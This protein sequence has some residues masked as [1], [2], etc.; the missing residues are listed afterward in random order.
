M[1]FLPW[2]ILYIIIKEPLVLFELMMRLRG[3]KELFNLLLII[4][5]VICTKTV[6]KSENNHVFSCE[7][8][9]QQVLMS[10]VCV[11]VCVSVRVS[12]MLK[13]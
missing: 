11:S 2:P 6:Q 5:V 13:L 4:K 3:T 10:S 8:A 12:P 9:A 7:D 1:R